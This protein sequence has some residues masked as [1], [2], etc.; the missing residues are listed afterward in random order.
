M[1][2]NVD[3]LKSINKV[4]HDNFPECDIVNDDQSVDVKVPT[5]F[6]KVNELSSVSRISYTEDIVNAYITYTRERPMTQ[7]EILTIQQRLKTCFDLDLDIVNDDKNVL[8]IDDKKIKSDSDSVLMI[9]SF[10]FLNGK[11]KEKDYDHKGKANME[12]LNYKDNKESF[13][14]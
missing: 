14:L 9:L 8:I 6:V 11:E 10:N 13:K 4:L 1:V 5:F 7:I 12:V 3:I 2:T